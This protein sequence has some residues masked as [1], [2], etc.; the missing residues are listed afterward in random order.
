MNHPRPEGRGST[1]MTEDVG[2]IVRRALEEDIGPGD[3]T[4]EFTTDDAATGR[5]TVRA[6]EPGVIAGTTVAR[7]VFHCVDS[8]TRVELHLADGERVSAGDTVLTV[9]GPASSI[10][11]AE[12][13]ALNFLQRMS[14]IATLTARYVGEV[15]GTRARITDTRKTAPGLRTTDKMAVKAGGGVNHR[16]GLY[17]MVLIKDNHIAAAGGITAAVSRCVAGLRNMPAGAARPAIEVETK[18]LTEVEE[19]VSCGGVSRIMLDNFPVGDM[20]RA[21]DMIGGRAEVEASGNVSLV[22]VRRIAES[23]VDFISIGALTHSAA[24][25][26]LSLEYSGAHAG[27]LPR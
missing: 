7:E 18:N 21:V 14:G 19:A 11:K 3:I 1:G 25:L 26:D 12:R 2:D 20:L 23:G 22:T 4:T 27:P 5:G 16:F 6:K 10:L 9:T 15:E 24:A 8:G 17:D 13:T